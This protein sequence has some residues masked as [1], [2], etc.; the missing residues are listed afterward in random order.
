MPCSRSINKLT[1]RPTV[2]A[3]SPQLPKFGRREYPAR[4][5]CCGVQP[6]DGAKRMGKKHDSGHSKA[7]G[8]GFVGLRRP[9][10]SGHCIRR[11][12]GRGSHR[13]TGTDRRRRGHGINSEPV[14]RER[15]CA[16]AVGAGPD[17]RGRPVRGDGRGDAE[18]RVEPLSRRQRRHAGDRQGGRRQLGDRPTGGDR[19]RPPAQ[20][21]RQRTHNRRVG[22]HQR[23]L[24]QG[25]VDLWQSPRT[26]DRRR[27][28]AEPCRSRDR[29]MGQG[30]SRSAQ[31]HADNDTCQSG[32]ARLA[33]YCIRRREQ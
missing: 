10:V 2:A 6:P 20:G 3:L 24:Y 5:I 22:L 15:R 25:R 33:H 8:A 27:Q 9:R 14:G 16:C 26:E 28:C 29:R 1:L 19:Q 7:A 11:C 12:R 30:H 17:R 18:R 21:R 32:H 4:D 31:Q 23:P 13:G